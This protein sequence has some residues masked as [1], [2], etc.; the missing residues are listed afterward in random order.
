MQ[1]PNE[2]LCS[3]KTGKTGLQI[4]VY[5]RKFYE[6]KLHLFILRKT[7]KALIEVFVSCTY[8]GPSIEI[9]DCTS[10]KSQ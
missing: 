7:L 3:G 10:P 6:S 5:W 8:W 1:D 4:D 2:E 9:F